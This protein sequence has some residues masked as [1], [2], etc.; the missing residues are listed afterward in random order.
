MPRDA[1]ATTPPAPLDQRYTGKT[2]HLSQGEHRNVRCCRQ[3]GQLRRLVK[4]GSKRVSCSRQAA[5]AA[6]AQ[7]RCA[8][9]QL[10]PGRL[11]SIREQEFGTEWHWRLAPFHRRARAYGRPDARLSGIQAPNDLRLALTCRASVSTSIPCANAIAG[12]QEVA[13]HG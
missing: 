4:R 7:S 10:T 11:Q 3:R 2:K 6:P 1:G 12:R 5:L 13:S 8:G 9:T